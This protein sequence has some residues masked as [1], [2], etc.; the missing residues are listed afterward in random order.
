VA[1]GSNTMTLNF[2]EVFSSLLSKEMREKNMELKSTN[3]L[4]ARGH[5]QG[6][7]RSMFSSGRCKS[8][9]RSKYH[10]NFLKVCWRCGK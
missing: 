1:I 9:G 6:R 3:T 4:F 7:N 2:H 5:S 10:G 8:K